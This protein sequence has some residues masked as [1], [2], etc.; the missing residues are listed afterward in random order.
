MRRAQ[1]VFSEDS[2]F[3]G[4]HRR[5]TDL[6]A[7]LHR[8]EGQSALF[9]PLHFAERIAALDRLEVILDLAEGTDE[10]TND[11]AL[12][13]RAQ[14]L[15]SQL[16][17]ANNALFVELRSEIQSGNGH[18]ALGRW[19]SA[20]QDQGTE[21]KPGLSYDWRDDL[22]TG[23]LELEEPDSPPVHP[24]G[25]M[26]FYQPTPARHIFEMLS[27]LNLGADDVLIDLGSGLGHVPLLAAITTP[28]QCIG[29]ELEPAYIESAR[30]CATD[31]GV[32]NVDFVTEDVSQ[33][34]LS[35]LSRATVFYLYTPF[36]GTLLTT[37]LGKLRDQALCRSIRIAA[38][39][40]CVEALAAKEWLETQ[41]P[42]QS[43]RI[44]VFFSRG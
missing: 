43:E 24:G 8:C 14:A 7:L 44:A 35:N 39:G 26:V 27:S 15:T 17:A 3:P 34:D 11:K 29:I 28:A 41:S 23:I 9:D 21:I 42:S 40:P 20:S 4:S 18:A 2:G 32:S 25:E 36:T 19:I 10:T 30:R 5:N 13:G 31:L 16:Q 1:F 33:A 22:V 37:V 12:L 38:F 6:E